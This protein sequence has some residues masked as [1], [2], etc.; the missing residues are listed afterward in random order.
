MVGKAPTLRENPCLTKG[1]KQLDTRETT[2]DQR[3]TALDAEAK[4]PTRKS[5]LDTREAVLN[6][7]ESQLNTRQQQATATQFAGFSTTE[8][9][10]IANT[11]KDAADLP[12]IHEALRSARSLT[13]QS[14]QK[15]PVVLPNVVPALQDGKAVYKFDWHKSVDLVTHP[16]NRRYFGNTITAYAKAFSF[17]QNSYTATPLNLGLD[18]KFDSKIL[19]TEVDTSGS[20]GA[21]NAKM[22]VEIVSDYSS[23]NTTDWLTYGL[24]VQVPKATLNYNDYKVGTFGIQNKKY[25]AMPVEVTGTATYKGG[26]LGLH[27]SLKNNEVKLSRFTGKATVTAN[28]GDAS[29]AGTFT[30]MI[31]ELKLDGQSVS[32]SIGRSNLAFSFGGVNVGQT[33]AG[34]RAGHATIDNV[35][36]LGKS[37]LT[38]TGPKPNNTTQPTGFTG[39]VNA[40]TSDGTKSFIAAFGARKE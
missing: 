40:K 25:G 39:Q 6:T 8:T 12:Y 24:W 11:V 10:N 1:K 4:D 26:M 17:N 38:T 13:Y 15:T 35:S 3:E 9:V 32:G 2:L 5:N 34:L 21:N 30:F 7:R 16:N 22:H 20:N 31:N 18:S 37:T 27:T 14:N 19:K 36:Y 23:D 33:N 29:Q 28:F